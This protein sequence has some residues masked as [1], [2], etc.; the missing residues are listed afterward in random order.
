[1]S[2]TATNPTAPVSAMGMDPSSTPYPIKKASA[3]WT[4]DQSSIDT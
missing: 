1:M 4:M 3:A 2:P